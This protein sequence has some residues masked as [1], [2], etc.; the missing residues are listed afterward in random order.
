MMGFRFS[1]SLHSTNESPFFL[2]YGFHMSLDI[3]NILGNIPTV[4]GCVH[5]YLQDLQTKL[6]LT[7]EV[8]KG[9]MLRYQQ[10]NKLRHDRTAKIPKFRVGQRVYL[11]VE[12][13]PVGV[14]R[15]LYPRYN[16]PYYIVYKSPNHS[17]KLRNCTTNKLLKYPVHASRLKV[18]RDPRDFRTHEPSFLDRL[19]SDSNVKR[20][21]N[22]QTNH[23]SDPPVNNQPPTRS[24]A[25]PS[26]HTHVRPQQTQTNKR[27]QA[28]SGHTDDS[29]ALRRTTEGPQQ[30]Q[31][32]RDVTSLATKSPGHQVPFTQGKRGCHDAMPAAAPQETSNHLTPPVIS[33][34]A[35]IPHAQASD[36]QAADETFYPAKCIKSAKKIRGVQHYLVS[37][38]DNSTPSWIPHYDCTTALIEQYF[39]EKQ[40][41]SRRRRKTRKR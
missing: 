23:E 41:K 26:F 29:T 40:N 36:S 33:P 39:V 14:S 17:Y 27:I 34:D 15:K 5:Q 28:Q 12:K 31:T 16:G 25:Q 13:I 11:T 10:I 6:K 30:A 38:E 9:N 4:T 7:R 20:P 24:V 1:P 21:A 2:C 35:V 3:D 18:C 22:D 19:L 32:R 8:A 37:W